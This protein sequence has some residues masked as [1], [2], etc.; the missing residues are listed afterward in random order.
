MLLNTYLNQLNACCLLVS[1]S[2][3]SL[4]EQQYFSKQ[5]AIDYRIPAANTDLQVILLERNQ[6]VAA[7]K[8]EVNLEGDNNL[9]KQNV[10]KLE[11]S[12][13]ILSRV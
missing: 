8:F 4:V 12:T 9:K 13:S 5:I 10:F 3:S 1:Q 6:D 11:A 2:P 7:L